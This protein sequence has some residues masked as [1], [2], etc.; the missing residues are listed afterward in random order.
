MS[1]YRSQSFKDLDMEFDEA[2]RFSVIAGA[3]G[4]GFA[5]EFEGWLKLFRNMVSPDYIIQNPETAEIPENTSAKVAI[6]SALA[7]R[8]NKKNL[9]AI[10]T[11]GER[12]EPEYR[13]KMIEYDIMSKDDSLKETGDYAQWLVKNQQFLNE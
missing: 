2:I 3:V 11:Y 8:A 10:M 4:Q 13:I 5:V 6:I 7:H 12:L 1:T 9:L